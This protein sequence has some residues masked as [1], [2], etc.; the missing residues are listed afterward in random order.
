MRQWTA[1]YLVLGELAPALADPLF[2]L[3]R[4]RG[5]EVL[6][7]PNLT[8]D[9]GLNWIFEKGHSSSE[10][11]LADGRALH[12]NQIS[13]AIIQKFAYPQVDV[14]DSGQRFDVRAE[15]EASWFG[16]FW[17][18]KCPVINRY[19]PI[20]WSSN[21]VPV[22]L[23]RSW[24]KQSGLQATD[25]V[26]SNNSEGWK[27]FVLGSAEEVTYTP[28]STS[29]VYRLTTEEDWSGLKKLAALVPVSLTCFKPPLYFA[30]VVGSNVF[31]NRAVPRVLTSIQPALIK[32]ATA[33]GLSFI[34]VG[35]LII[36]GQSSVYSVDPFPK[37]TEFKSGRCQE[38]VDA[39][40]SEMESHLVGKPKKS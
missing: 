38:I 22:S 7:I 14:A 27:R 11:R 16:W 8:S 28:L 21:S 12:E 5:K 35:L 3:L 19:P 30:S 20:F 17:S 40:V 4:E 36:D 31:W 37:L 13:A 39:L 33:A 6:H 15:Q 24:M 32:L 2:A 26:L 25:A 29:K 18:L 23:W 1:V 34:E 9:V 10:L